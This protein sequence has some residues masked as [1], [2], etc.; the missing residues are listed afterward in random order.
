MTRLLRFQHPCRFQGHLLYGIRSVAV[1]ADRLRTVVSG[2][3]QA[4]KSVDAR[5]KYFLS[6]VGEFDPFPAK[7]LRSELPALEAARAS[8]A[9][10]ISELA[11]AEPQLSVCRPEESLLF[12]ANAMGAVGQSFRDI[13]FHSES[14]QKGFDVDELNSLLAEARS[15]IVRVRSALA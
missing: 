11:D 1:F 6:Y 7:G 8:L 15:S 4:E 5:D 3:A 2:C 14:K 10:T 12:S 9:A 13:A